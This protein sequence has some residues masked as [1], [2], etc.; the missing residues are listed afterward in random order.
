M[1]RPGWSGD[2]ASVDQAA[3]VYYSSLTE[4]EIAEHA[5]WGEF[6]LRQLSCDDCAEWNLEE[7]ERS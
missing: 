1:S 2:R 7:T 5:A 4:E 3:S 6:A